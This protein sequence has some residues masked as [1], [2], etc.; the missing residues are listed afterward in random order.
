MSGWVRYSYKHFNKCLSVRRC[1]ILYLSASCPLREQEP[2]VSRAP[3]G[4]LRSKL[5]VESGDEVGVDGSL[6]CL[7]RKRQVPRTPVSQLVHPAGGWLFVSWHIVDCFSNSPEA[8]DNGCMSNAIPQASTRLAAG[9][10]RVLRSTSFVED[11]FPDRERGT[12]CQACFSRFFMYGWRL[13]IYKPNG[14]QDLRLD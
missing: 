4:S 9:H 8:F 6:L 13:A 3:C 1:A 7:C 5:A 2:H 10:T 14:A 11:R 12:Q